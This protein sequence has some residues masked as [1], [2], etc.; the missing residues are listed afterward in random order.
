LGIN[1]RKKRT[2]L[3]QRTVGKPGRTSTKNKKLFVLSR[4]KNT[5]PENQRNAKPS[6]NACQLGGKT[7]DREGIKKKLK[8]GWSHVTYPTARGV[9]R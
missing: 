8:F 4:R 2:G 7:E 6:K 1:G 9:C 5:N 3:G